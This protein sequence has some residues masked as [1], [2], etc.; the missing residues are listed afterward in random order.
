M[1]KTGKILFLCL[2]F[3]SADFQLRSTT[4]PDKNKHESVNQ[5]LNFWQDL[6][7]FISDLKGAMQYYCP[8]RPVVHRCLQDHFQSLFQL[9]LNIKKQGELP[10]LLG[11]MDQTIY[12]LGQ[13]EVFLRNLALLYKMEA[14]K[15]FCNEQMQIDLADAQA[16]IYI[17]P[18]LKRLCLLMAKAVEIRNIF[19]MTKTHLDAAG[20][21]C[22]SIASLEFKSKEKM[23][24][25]NQKDLRMDEP[26]DDPDLAVFKCMEKLGIVR[27]EETTFPLDK[28]RIEF[29]LN[30][31]KMLYIDGCVIP[32]FDPDKNEKL[33]P[34]EMVNCSLKPD[35]SGP[36]PFNNLTVKCEPFAS[37][38]TSEFGTRIIFE[39][40]QN[41]F[42]Q[43]FNDAFRGPNAERKFLPPN[44][45]Q[46]PK[47][48]DRAGQELI[49]GSRI[50]FSSK[51]FDQNN[52]SN[53]S[54]DDGFEDSS[55]DNGK[56]PKK[57]ENNS[58]SGNQNLDK[59]SKSKAENKPK[60][61]FLGPNFFDKAK[62]EMADILYKQ[63]V[64][65]SLTPESNKNACKFGGHLYALGAQD[66]AE[67]IQNYTERKDAFF[68]GLQLDNASMQTMF[69]NLSKPISPEDC[70]EIAKHYSSIGQTLPG[71]LNASAK[72]VNAICQMR[73]ARAVEDFQKG[74]PLPNDF[75]RQLTQVQW[76][77]LIN[78]S[79]NTLGLAVQTN[80][81]L[82]SMHEFTN[83]A[84]RMGYKMGYSDCIN[85]KEPIA[86]QLQ[87][88][89]DQEREKNEILQQQ[90]EE[91]TAD[92]EKK[93][94]ILNAATKHLQNV[95]ETQ[96][97]RNK[98]FEDKTAAFN[99]QVD[100]LNRKVQ[101]LE[102]EKSTWASEKSTLE[103]EKETLLKNSKKQISA[104]IAT[105]KN[106][107]SEAQTRSQ[108]PGEEGESA[109]S[110]PDGSQAVN[111]IQT[112]KSTVS[113][114]VVD[115]EK[116]Q[117]RL[118]IK[119][120]EAKNQ[121]LEQ[122]QSAR[123]KFYVGKSK[124]VSDDKS[125]NTDL[126]NSLFKKGYEKRMD[127]ERHLKLQA[128]TKQILAEKALFEEK[129]KE[130]K[131]SNDKDGLIDDLK[132]E[133]NIIKKENNVLEKE[134]KLLVE[135]LKKAES[136]LNDFIEE[137]CDE[138][139]GS[140]DKA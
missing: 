38:E 1:H 131:E 67:N 68:Q 55:G 28:P 110:K 113:P 50:C 140:G 76:Q 70:S 95:R 32:I 96:I 13:I 15:G 94:Q 138:I 83:A 11:V 117:M 92:N 66:M 56:N 46:K 71:D 136:E 130:I 74:M 118:R 134:K 36:G 102:N 106:R 16:Q 10:D 7:I 29:C 12:D 58:K 6:F 30:N 35:L 120:L 105:V 104:F 125:K 127:D 62:T 3:V 26:F 129:I 123:P 115:D 86:P 135:N 133:N 107:L 122:S 116:E 97:N 82:M 48:L 21:D 85:E 61:P 8:D 20:K 65:K 87:S 73:I 37:Q 111:S 34:S 132:E 23:I 109:Q 79:I 14:S 64:F 51:N 139:G 31:Q 75:L 91:S 124:K 2:S 4:V 25:F 42:F 54:D 45:S 90:L 88:M 57:P 103:S 101:S 114:S 24:N 100:A 52:G 98:E 63:G 80:T 69:R 89:L 119:E 81:Y 22:I 53:N 17:E 137:F 18:I 49:D 41:N 60:E 59:D 77:Q 43:E 121:E 84:T 78:H 19:Y 72:E 128:K 9:D 44:T 112:P 108:E 99:A 47:S 40:R 126:E 39:S 33:A 93:T 5:F 27:M